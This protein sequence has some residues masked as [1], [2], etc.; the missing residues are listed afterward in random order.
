M[1]VEGRPNLAPKFSVVVEE[2]LRGQTRESVSLKTL[3]D[4][5]AEVALLTRIIGDHP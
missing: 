3:D 1:L 4:K 2:H 5:R